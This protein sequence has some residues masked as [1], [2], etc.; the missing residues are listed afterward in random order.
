MVGRAVA[1]DS[2]GFAKYRPPELG[3][4]S[5]R[6]DFTNQLATGRAKIH[7]PDTG[8]VVIRAMGFSAGDAQGYAQTCADCCLRPWTCA[9]SRT[10]RV[11]ACQRLQLVFDAC[12][13]KRRRELRALR[14]CSVR[15]ATSVG[16]TTAKSTRWA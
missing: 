11:M 10:P 9:C 8:W 5:A 12:V 2:S 14:R 7:A 16:T 1:V 15:C 4:R 13:A 6:V 3:G